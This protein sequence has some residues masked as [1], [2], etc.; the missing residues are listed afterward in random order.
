MPGINHVWAIEL[1]LFFLFFFF[2]SL[3]L[4]DIQALSFIHPWA[5]S[6][7]SLCHW[8]HGCCDPRRRLWMG[9]SCCPCSPG[10]STSGVFV[11]QGSV[12]RAV[13]KIRLWVTPGLHLTRE[14]SVRNEMS[15]CQ[16]HLRRSLH[17]NSTSCRAGAVQG[18]WKPS[19]P[20]CF[21]CCLLQNGK[22]LFQL[23]MAN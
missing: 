10:G 20:H 12:E 18:V 21:S 19:L 8:I 5:C 6:A 16:W 3:Q 17:R 9:V 15:P 22:W 2:L 4:A 1:G 14:A 23:W 7:L 11:C 13:P